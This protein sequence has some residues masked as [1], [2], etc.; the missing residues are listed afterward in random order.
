M[1]DSQSPKVA[2][3]SYDPACLVH[4]GFQ[5]QIQETMLAL[6][7][8]GCDTHYLEWWN[9]RQKPDIIHVFGRPQGMM[10][11]YAHQKGIKVVFSDLLT[12]QGSRSKVRLLCQ[13]WGGRVARQFLPPAISRL[14][15]WNSYQEADAVVALTEWEKSLMC[16]LYGADPQKIHVIPNGVDDAFLSKSCDFPAEVIVSDAPLLCVATITPRKRVLEVAHAATESGIPIQFIG[17]P[18]S[19][20][21]PYYLDFLN[22]VENS[23]G[24]LQY[25]GSIQ[26]RARLAAIYRSSKGFVLASTM[27]S[28]SLAAL[29]AAA[30][31]LPMLL[32][33]LPWAREVF[34]NAPSYIPNY[35]T[36]LMLKDLL[37]SFYDNSSIRAESFSLPL[38]WEHVGEK[39]YLIYKELLMDRYEKDN[40]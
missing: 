19:E 6:Q 28:Q 23:R 24:R 9:Q 10:I 27:E 13:E 12:E 21:D 20:K 32:S 31:D 30:S 37:K 4:G 14:A 16:R 29:E 18:Y 7:S 15:G 36:P 5:I 26:D 3:F 11:Q 33:D 40:S 34:G 22:V 25:L 1:P 2:F 38:S 39:I 8:L 35:C 17:A